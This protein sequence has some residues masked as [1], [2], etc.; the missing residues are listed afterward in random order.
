MTVR[1]RC[2]GC[3]AVR[4]QARQRSSSQAF[5]PASVSKRGAGLKKRPRPV[6][7]WFST[8]PFSQPAEG[9]QA[10]G[11]TRGCEQNCWE[12]R[13]EKGRP[14]PEKAPPPPGPFLL[15]AP[16]PRTPPKKE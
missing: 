12:R 13:V 4:A 11:S 7:T 3:A 9:L 14:P 16:P 1:S 8:C 15:K 2:T 10:V 5:R 6:R